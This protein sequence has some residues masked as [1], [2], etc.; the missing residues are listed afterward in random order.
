MYSY[1]DIILF[2]KVVEYK[3]F[4]RTA[5]VLNIGQSTIS[6]RIKML[7]ESLGFELFYQ[8]GINLLLTEEGKLLYSKLDEQKPLFV[9]LDNFIENIKASKTQLSGKIRVV[10]PSAISQFSFT[11][12]L[13]EFLLKYPKIS[14]DVRYQNTKVDLIKEDIDIAIINHIPE[15]MN[16]KYQKLLSYTHRLYCS[17]EYFNKYGIPIAPEDLRHHFVA[18]ALDTSTDQVVTKVNFI[19]IQTGKVVSIEVS[20]RISTNNNAN[21]MVLLE[22]NELMVALSDLLAKSRND[23]IRVLPDYIIDHPAMSLYI[24]K[25]PHKDMVRTDLFAN[26]I[27]EKL[28]SEGY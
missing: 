7:E 26:F 16:Q 13:P 6:R 27:R 19:N 3:T 8:N 2:A 17:K 9:G 21:A 10:L 18:T 20:D 1:D 23:L 5:K 24:I 22:S 25:H 12:F 11:K 14:L 15:Q 4:T 28:K